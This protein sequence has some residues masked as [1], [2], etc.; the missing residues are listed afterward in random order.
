MT[1]VIGG[2]LSSIL[3]STSVARPSDITPY[4][5]CITYDVQLKKGN[6]CKVLK[7]SKEN[8]QL[9][10]ID[11]LIGAIND[12]N[13]SLRNLLKEKT[14]VLD[15]IQTMLDFCAYTKTPFN[16]SQLNSFTHFTGVYTR[17]AGALQSTLKKIDSDKELMAAKKEL[18][19]NE[20]NYNAIIAELT[21][22]S[23]SL[24]DAI[25]YLRGI[26]ESGNSTLQVL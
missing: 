20:A 13:R 25:S 19:H 18:L 3:I 11:E 26:I 7:I 6:V 8:L 17:E 15:R 5:Y 14:K 4:A 12:Q 1:I 16:E 22:F 24:G 21:S 2:L 10:K 9:M 23:N